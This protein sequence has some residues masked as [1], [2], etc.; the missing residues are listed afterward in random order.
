[1]EYGVK[2][3]YDHEDAT[4]WYVS[5]KEVGS[6]VQCIFTVYEIITVGLSQFS[7]FEEWNF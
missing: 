6:A 5:E 1:M 7:G 3:K 4:Y 2:S